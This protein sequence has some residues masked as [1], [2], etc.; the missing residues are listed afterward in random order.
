M[1]KIDNE[2]KQQ[3]EQVHRNMEN[4]KKYLDITQ[5]KPLNR[6]FKR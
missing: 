2:S 5:G 4:G 1:V 6:D 3:R